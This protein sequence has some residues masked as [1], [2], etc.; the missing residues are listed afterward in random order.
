MN[1]VRANVVPEEAEKV[2]RRPGQG[3]KVASSRKDLPHNSLHIGVTK[4]FVWVP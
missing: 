3:H 1:M 4:E 2:S